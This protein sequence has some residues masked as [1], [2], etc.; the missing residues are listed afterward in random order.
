MSPSETYITPQSTVPVDGPEADTYWT[1]L[2]SVPDVLR[3][4]MADIETAEFINTLKTQ[5]KLTDD[6]RV[7]VAEFLRD[8]L[9]GITLPD[10]TVGALAE[11]I[12]VKYST[13]NQLIR[14]IEK[15]ILSKAGMTIADIG[16]AII[17]PSI[18]EEAGRLL[19]RYERLDDLL[20]A[21]EDMSSNDRMQFLEDAKTDNRI[22]VLRALTQ[23]KLGTDSKG[24][25]MTFAQLAAREA[26]DF[27]ATD[28]VDALSEDPNFAQNA[29][30]HKALV[31]FLASTDRLTTVF[32][33]LTDVKAAHVL[34]KALK[35]SLL[36]AKPA[37][38]EYVKWS[39]YF[40]GVYDKEK[41]IDDKVFRRYAE[42]P[43]EMRKKL[44]SESLSKRIAAMIEDGI[45]PR[46]YGVAVA[47]I[48]FLTTL[49]E[50][51]PEAL[52]ILLGER[53]GLG[54]K[55]GMQV[56]EHVTSVL[57]GDL[58]PPEEPPESEEEETVTS[59]ENAEPSP[60]R[61]AKKKRDAKIDDMP[62]VVDLRESDSEE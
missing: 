58:M 21:I 1:I 5:F 41:D 45:V 27:S 20:A 31:T 35:E 37:V 53:L 60:E 7:S 47:K 4:L 3:D 2:R 49:G 50:I 28:W 54:A 6:Q 40:A 14:E 16:R 9:M 33:K 43:E 61:S 19:L 48:T 52:P 15:K 34:H 8:I 42:L 13:A 62:N 55:N 30:V 51:R 24:R 10:D 59:E 22:L 17:G 32:G 25:P 11:R 38:G 57:L 46:N 18:R 36:R 44:V 29:D 23:L 26:P 12:G 56:A 39:P